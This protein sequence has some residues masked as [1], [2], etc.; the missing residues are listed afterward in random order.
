MLIP[1]A[2]RRLILAAPGMRGIV[3][4]AIVVKS[5][6]SNA[7]N[8][9]IILDTSEEVCRLG[10][11]D[12]EAI[13]TLRDNGIKLCQSPGL[14]IGIL[15]CD[16]DA[17]IF[18][19]TALYIQSEAQSAETPNA[20]HVDSTVAQALAMRLSEQE[21]DKAFGTPD[22]RQ[23]IPDKIELGDF[24]LTES[25]LS[26]VKISLEQ[27]PPIPFN[28]ARQVRVFEPYIQYVDIK[29][30]GAAIQRKRITLP[31]GIV[32]LGSD[33]DI[34]NRI[35]T[36]FSLIERDSSLS[37][38]KLEKELDAIREDFTRP[39]GN[40][41]G[42]VML[43]AN[44]IAF[45]DAIAKFE[46]K[47]T[48]HQESIKKGLCAHMETALESLVNHYK[49]IVINNPPRSL[50]GQI[51]E[52][53]PTE[54]QAETWLEDELLGILPDVKKLFQEMQVIV[55]FRDVT[56]ETL[57][58]EKFRGLIKANFPLVHWDKPFKE[59]QAISEDKKKEGK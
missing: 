59:F 15:I 6:E 42:R 25:E 49:T 51:A 27:A 43:K 33:E 20:T 54:R 24:E 36:T 29:L 11:G 40:P 18:T 16:D 52:T 46:D 14:R 47:V 56:Y 41:Y 28:I 55:Q 34:Q 45:D 39:L 30:Q 31:H 1:A 23:E 3:A 13:T 10:Y 57:K 35:N 2:K 48:K 37:S 50:S 21:R 9:K 5:R 19:P 22:V 53:K 12:L 8:I 44:R 38:K 26:D 58:D 4:D 7:I 17:W 32:N